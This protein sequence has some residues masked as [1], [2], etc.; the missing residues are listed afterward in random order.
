MNKSEL[1]AVVAEKSGIQKKDAE[2][3][4]AATFET[5]TA[6]LM[7]GKKLKFVGLVFSFF[8]WLLLCGLVGGFASAFN[9]VLGTIVTYAGS[10]LLT[11]YMTFSEIGFYEDVAG[12]SD[13][14]PTTVETT[15]EPSP[16]S[17]IE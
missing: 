17:T 3:V 15:Y 7:K 2:R 13:V 6:E 1:T 8:G 4:V 14:A 5:I 9:S 16:E 10:L 11:P 12:I